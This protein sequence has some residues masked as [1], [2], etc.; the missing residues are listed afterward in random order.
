MKLHIFKVVL[1]P[2]SKPGKYN[3]L[4]QTDGEQRR[5]DIFPRSVGDDT[6]YGETITH[7]A[8]HVWS[9]R[10]WGHADDINPTEWNKWEEWE[11]C[12]QADRIALSGYARTDVEEDLAETYVAYINTKGSPKFEEYRRIVPR[13]FAMLDREYEP[14]L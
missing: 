12:M 10:T 11:K 4:A 14:G 13:R 5:I 6:D 9:K 2:T 8:G 7:E 1:N 3:T